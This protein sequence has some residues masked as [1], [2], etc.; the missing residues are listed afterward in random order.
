M[1]DLKA[2]SRGKWFGFLHNM[3]RPKTACRLLFG[4]VM[5]ISRKLPD[6]IWLKCQSESMKSQISITPLRGRRNRGSGLIADSA[7][8]VRYSLHHSSIKAPQSRQ[9]LRLFRGSHKWCRLPLFRALQV[10]HHLAQPA[11]VQVKKI[12]MYHNIWSYGLF[13]RFFPSYQQ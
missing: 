12:I 10:V 7:P 1:L 8:M 6:H 5:L 3:M 4:C 2:A 11:E 13:Q 9:R